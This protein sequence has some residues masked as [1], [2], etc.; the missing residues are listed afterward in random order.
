MRNLAH[1]AV[2]QQIIDSFADPECRRKIGPWTLDPANKEV[3]DEIIRVYG[4]ETVEKLRCELVL[5]EW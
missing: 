3:L 4:A 1:S 5:G 2:L